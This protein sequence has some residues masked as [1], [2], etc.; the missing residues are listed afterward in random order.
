MD[1]L[2]SLFRRITRTFSGTENLKLVG[3][4]HYKPTPPV[5]NQEAIESHQ[6]TL[7]VAFKSHLFDH[8]IDYI[9]SETR[10][11][12]VDLE[13]IYADFF[14]GDVPPCPEPTDPKAIAALDYALDCMETAFAPP[15]LARPVH[16]HDIE[17]HYPFKWNVNSEVPFSTDSYF[18]DNRKPYADFY[19]PHT[20][21]WTHYVNPE[22]LDKRF[23]PNPTRDQLATLTPA[24]FGFMK[25]MI[26]SWT[27]R[28]H[29]IIKSGYTDTTGLESTPYFK[30]RFIF[31][32]LLHTKTAIVKRNDPN[33]MRTIW[34]CSKPWIIA[35][36]IFYWELLAWMKLNPGVTPILWGYETFTGG[37]LRL[38][39]A[40]FN[41]YVRNSFLTIDWSRF[42]KRAYFWLIRRIMYRVRKYLDF[43]S[44]YVPTYA[45][46]SH[47]NWDER[48]HEERLHRLWEWTLENLFNSNI[49][50]SDGRMYTR[51]F[52]G[53]PSGLYITQL[54]DSWYNYASLAFLI[55]MMDMD[56]KACIIKVQGDDSVIRLAVLIP[57]SEH[58]TFLN[59][60]AE[61]A[62]LFLKSKL[63][64]EKSELRNNL[65]GVEVL[66]YRNH[67]G[68]PSRDEIAVLAIFYHTKAKN[69]TPSVTM[70]AAAGF[71]Y[72][73]V[74]NNRRVYD[75]LKSVY[76]YY[77]EQGYTPLASA[78]ANIVFGDSPD[79][80]W[81]PFTL[82]HFPSI[83]EIK[84]YM[85]GYTYRNSEQDRRTWPLTHFINAPCT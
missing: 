62:E 76:S 19:D 48:K 20:K 74:G 23:G 52:A 45:Y 43:S 36:T 5:V 27:R 16:L 13:S 14:A 53:I 50:L 7:R 37:W 60:M 63:N 34:G 2:T 79:R 66:S 85:T 46:P 83:S 40:L 4:Y 39:A 72:A 59:A 73:S 55:I 64:F 25:G 77:A 51:D 61:Q 11:S 22:V 78:G 38:N 26:F 35:D 67:D 80:P 15:R 10:R 33:K 84:Q 30:Q 54:L 56:P 32:M 68:M 31:P 57:P 8:E 71:A 47:P 1:Y 17:H 18:L 65:N 69:P 75:C 58:E 24:K 44:G 28:W 3:E 29:H 6:R 21:R 82:D 42:D 12:K 9:T 41:G 70:A 49:V 81:L